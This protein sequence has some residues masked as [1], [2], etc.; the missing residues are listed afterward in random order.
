MFERNKVFKHVE[1]EARHEIELEKYVKKVQIESRVLREM[2][3]TYVVPAAI[4]YQ[5]QHRSWHGEIRC[6]CVDPAGTRCIII[7]IR[8]FAQYI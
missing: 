7:S 4:S 6:R 2:A 8:W 3:L 5:N 1:I